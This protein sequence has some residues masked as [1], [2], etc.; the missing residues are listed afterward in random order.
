MTTDELITILSKKE[1]ELSEKDKIE[2][3]KIILHYPINPTTLELM[4]LE[5]LLSVH[6]YT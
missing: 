4:H 6:T 5:R 1:F 3:L 2:I